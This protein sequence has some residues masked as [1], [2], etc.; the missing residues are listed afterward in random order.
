M[1]VYRITKQKYAKNISGKGAELFGGRW[2]PI[3]IPALYTSE[4]RALCALELLVHTP[5]DILPPKY[6]LL[7]INIPKELEKEI[8]TLQLIDLDKSW[9]SLQPEIWT[10]E[11]GRK[12]FQELN[13][14]GIRVPSTI[15]KDENNIILNPL[16]PKYNKVE[17]VEKSDF[18]L[19]IRLLK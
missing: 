11:I 4:N 1:Q 9:D 19:D 3:G 2:N 14:I 5:K 10:E 16:H 7:T 13:K 8:E 17:V 6:V 15:I 12:Y 18:N